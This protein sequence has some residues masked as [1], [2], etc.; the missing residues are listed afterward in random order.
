MTAMTAM[1]NPTPQFEPGMKA[2]KYALLSI[3]GEWAVVLLSARI[4]NWTKCSVTR[5][6]IEL[7]MIVAS[8][9]FTPNFT[10]KMPGIQPYPAP[11]SMAATISANGCR[12]GGKWTAYPNQAAATAP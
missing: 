9:S 6:A 1:T 11:T 5:A 7:S 8:S 12:R 4:G 2:G 10:F 3:T